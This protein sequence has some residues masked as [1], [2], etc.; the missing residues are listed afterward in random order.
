M[1]YICPKEKCSG[2]GLCADICPQ[3]AITMK[4]KKLT[5]HFVP[6]VDS[7]KCIN[8][9]LC[10]KKCPSN[11]VPHLYKTINTYVAWKKDVES[12]KTSSS[13]GIAAELYSCAIKQGY[14]VTGVILD[15]DFRAK[16]IL[17]NT[18]E[19]LEKFKLSKYM[20]A[21]CKGIFSGIKDCFK[22]KQQVLFI[23]TPCQC[24]AARKLAGERYGDFLTTVELICHGVP[25]QKIFKEYVNDVI[26]SNKV[27]DKILFRTELGEELVLYSQNKVIWKRR[28]FQDDY[29]TAFQEGILSNEKCYQCPYATPNRGSD[30]TIGDFWGIGEVR[31][32][33]RPQ[34]RVSVLLV[35]TEKGK[36]LLELCDGLYLEERDNCEAVNG[37]GQLKGPAKKSA[38][39]ELFWNVYRRKGI[40]SA[41][42]CTVHR[43]TSYA[44]LK[45]KYWGG[46]KRSIKRVLV[47]TGV[48]R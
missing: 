4:E 16:M 22:L 17:S 10:H 6:E 36:Q 5:G 28:S 3:K 24:D 18:T 37:N 34:C 45:D 38:K 26:A 20:Q 42:D 25:S 47:K 12:T 1:V 48:M 19:Y 2:C 43:K 32:F 39:Y 31:S 41:M 30:L 33:S 35:N 11:S 27:I 23:G 40:K 8:C 7:T 9:S 15:E 46:I 44:Y 13:G 21:D 14:Y 29:L